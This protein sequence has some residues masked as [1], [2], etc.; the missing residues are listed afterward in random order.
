MDS[1]KI[2]DLQPAFPLAKGEYH[3]APKPRR[4]TKAIIYLVMSA[5]ALAFAFMIGTGG[6]VS[7]VLILLITI[8]VPIA[9]A[10]INYPKFGIVVLL[11]AAYFV[12]FV[13]RMGVNFPLGTL[14][15]GIEAFL[16]LGIFIFQK[17]RP[18]PDWEMVKSPMAI[19]ILVWVVYNL[20]Q[21]A[22]PTTES[23]M[24]WVYTIRAVAVV[25]LMYFV[26]VF[27]IRDIKF[28]RF[29]LK[30][31]IGLALFAAMYAFK[32]E[33]F[34]FFRFEELDVF[35]KRKLL[36]IAGHWRKFSIFSDPVAFS[37]NMVVSSLLCFS[38]LMGPFS[39]T[40][41][42][43][44]ACIGCFLLTTMMYSGTRGAY[45]LVP[46][47]L[48][49]FALL[50]YSK[51]VMIVSMIGGLFLVA[52]IFVP[53]GNPT[54]KRFQSA[55]RPSND[56][57]YLLRKQN[58]KMIQPFI[59]SHP[60]GGG[61]GATGVW[62]ARFAPRSF[63]ARF[64]P[65]SGYT[66]VAVELG[67]IGLFLFCTLMFVIMRTG[68]T[69]YYAIKDPEL[70]SYALGMTLIIF[71]YVIGNYPQEALV[72]FPSNIYFYLVAAFITITY[73]LDQE[74]Q[75]EKLIATPEQKPVG[76]SPVK[77]AVVRPRT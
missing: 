67:W 28:I 31:W 10:I 1:R 21:F 69:N 29:I 76:A 7:A 77:S 32:Q 15:D 22:N 59:L 27:H 6:M 3:P 25:M 43:I 19:M 62:G 11:V 13:I 61:L 5:C 58:Q 45:V 63:L 47:G 2:Y 60:L 17:K 9:F 74:M 37:Y 30:L 65:D 68:I 18:K 16:I 23:R 72:Q 75:K 42:I 46:A 14:M 54:I 73:R 33:Y 24:A 40:K 26:F 48:V 35:P 50:N 12:M 66:R 39:K 64:P 8:G 20:I 51:R 38:L 57:S 4:W 70:K 49:M 34:G 56:A 36:F 55:F 44:L 71:V 41:K 52:L 53:T